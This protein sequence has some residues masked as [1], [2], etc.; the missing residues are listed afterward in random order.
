MTQPSI[1]SSPA[2]VPVCA[3]TAPA[4]TSPAKKAESYSVY[5]EINAFGDVRLSVEA[6]DGSCNFRVVSQQLVAA[7]YFFRQ[8]LGPNSQLKEAVNFRS[9]DHC[10]LGPFPLSIIIDDHPLDVC[11]LIL[12]IL[13]GSAPLGDIEAGKAQIEDLCEM[14]RLVQYFDCGAALSPWASLVAPNLFDPEDSNTY[15]MGVENLDLWLFIAC[16]LRLV[17]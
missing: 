6:Q 9:H 11:E 5:R 2:T 16:T 17:D 15:V 4:A 13:H 14:A 12:L 10:Q 7:Y 8:L 3:S 1:F